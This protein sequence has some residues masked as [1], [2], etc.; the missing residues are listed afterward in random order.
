MMVIDIFGG[1]PNH[2]YAPCQRMANAIVKH[3][4][5]H[6]G[7]EPDDLHAIGFTREETA[8]HWHMAKAMA[9]IELKWLDMDELPE[10]KRSRR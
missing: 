10:E 4:K 6:G 9:S 1:D 3:I 8:A 2:K 5:E 7:C